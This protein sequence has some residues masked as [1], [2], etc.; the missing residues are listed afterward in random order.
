[1]TRKRS[2]TSQQRALRRFGPAARC[3]GPHPLRTQPRADRTH[4][5]LPPA[6]SP[7]P[8]HGGLCV[9]WTPRQ[10]GGGARAGGNATAPGPRR[11]RLSPSKG[12]SH[13][14]RADHWNILSCEENSKNAVSR[15]TGS[16]HVQA[17]TRRVPL[18]PRRTRCAARQPP[19]GRLA[20]R[21]R[22]AGQ[23]EGCPGQGH[24]RPRPDPPSGLPFLLLPSKC[25]SC[26]SL[27][28]NMA[29]QVC[30]S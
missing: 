29:V 10:P 19:G 26:G 25:L 17:S 18:A 11:A 21:R 30:H 13:D 24:P 27:K 20:L 28:N 7:A 5:P 2:E 8:Q 1:M 14:V 3:L 16:T 23:R 12:N 6:L 9:H 15:T 4:C 22:A